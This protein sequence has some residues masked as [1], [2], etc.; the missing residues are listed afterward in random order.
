MFETTDAPPHEDVNFHVPGN[1]VS[2][3]KLLILPYTFFKQIKSES[4][5]GYERC[6]ARKV[7][8]FDDYRPFFRNILGHVQSEQRKNVAKSLSLN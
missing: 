4:V 3:Q 8:D 5:S 1:Y 7:I 6:L 2:R